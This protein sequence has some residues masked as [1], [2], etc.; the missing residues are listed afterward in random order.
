MRLL[1][2]NI[3]SI[4]RNF[5]ELEAF[6]AE[7]SEPE[8]IALTE[9]W[10]SKS[11]THNYFSL[12]NYQNLVVANREKRGGGSAFYVRK[13]LAYK[14][15][16]KLELNELQILTNFFASVHIFNSCVQTAFYKMWFYVKPAD[17]IHTQLKHTLGSETLGLW[18]LQYRLAS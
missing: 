16:A 12:K 7:T 11:P 14:V 1:L 5:S 9:T 13:N 3:R 2:Q 18:G 8:V 17:R 10:L 15:V 4:T 6:L